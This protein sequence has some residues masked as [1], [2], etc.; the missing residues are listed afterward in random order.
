VPEDGPAAHE[1]PVEL[2]RAAHVTESA[3]LAGQGVPV[4]DVNDG[5]IAGSPVRVY[6]PEAARGTIAYCTAA[7]G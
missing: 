6:A 2:A 5:E 4:H 1:V 7:A 3:V